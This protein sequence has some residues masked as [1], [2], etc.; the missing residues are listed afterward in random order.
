MSTNNIIDDLVEQN[1]YLRQRNIALTTE[2]NNLILK[3]AIKKTQRNEPTFVDKVEEIKLRLNCTVNEALAIIA[4]E[5][6]VYN[7]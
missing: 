4:M 1:D 6:E 5:R 2:R 7:G 3:D